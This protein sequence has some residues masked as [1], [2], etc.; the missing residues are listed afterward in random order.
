MAVY[1]PT[2]RDKA[3]GEKKQQDVWWYH[4]RYAGT[5]IQESAKTTRRTIAVKAEERRKLE[6]ERALAGL[7]S[8]KAADRIRTVL[9]ALTAYRKGYALAHRPKSVAW[10]AE[11]TVHVERLLGNT[12]MPDLTEESIHDYMVTRRAEGAGNRSINMEVSILSR[13]LGH[14]WKTLWPK[15][16]PLEENRDV[17][18]AL[19]PEQE[20]AVLE[21]ASRTR[22]HLI[23]PYLVVLV[24]T[25]MRSSEA[26][27]LRWSQVDFGAGQI[28]VGNSKTTA[29]KGRQIPMSAALRFALEHHASWYASKLGTIEPDWYVF[30]RSNRV[31]PEDPTI[32]A[33]TLKSS[34]EAVRAT[35]GVK[36]RLH[37]LRHSFCTKMAESGTPEAT[38]LDM[39]G[40]VSVS[41]LRRYSHVRSQAR[42]EAITALEN[43]AASIG[44]AKVSAKVELLKVPKRSVTN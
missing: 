34:W 29:G 19:D 42:R 41:M 18:K 17:G 24:W 38:M 30:P 27:L 36:C 44:V 11:R 23:Y 13:A 9:G 16:R 15:A 25:G 21:A 4:F 2:Y 10:V 7:P 43:R 8:E 33:T 5:R 12:L 37:D 31:K 14:T 35:A 28:T 32:P 3:T 40:H 20:A 22:S 1:K 39:M 6:L 26:R